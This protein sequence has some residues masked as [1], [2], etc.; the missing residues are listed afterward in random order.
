VEANLSV[1][2]HRTLLLLAV[3]TVALLIVGARSGAQQA[4]VT[5][6]KSMVPD[7]PSEPKPPLQ[8][9]PY[10]HKTHLAFGL[11]CK[12]CHTNPAPGNLMTFPETGKCMECHETIAK[13]KP[14]VQKLAQYARE[15]KAIPW[16]RVY[17]VLPGVSWTHRAH[18][19]AGVKCET[20]HGQV[21]Q[22]E[23]MFES[24]SVTTMYSCLSCHEINHAKTGCETC[25]KK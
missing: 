18:L 8:P 7:N 9:I 20:C 19:N 6:T 2:R 4:A 13:D 14:A 17:T 12:E 15:R 23:A 10:S 5:A 16:V 25:H 3:A 1:K 22:M 21:A 11:A 24:T